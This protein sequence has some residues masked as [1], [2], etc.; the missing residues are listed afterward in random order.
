M[1]SKEDY[2]AEARTNNPKPLFWIANGIEIELTD[3]EYEASIVAWAEM[4]VAQ[5]LAQAEA[6]AVIA[7]KR[8][9]Y[10]KF[11]LT[12]DEINALLGTAEGNTEEEGGSE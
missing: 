4:R 5:D 3:D 2:I 11:G 12:D 6:E 8:S 7:V 1:K 9:A 10:T